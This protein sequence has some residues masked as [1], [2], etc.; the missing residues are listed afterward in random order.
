MPKS[1]E[2]TI[3]PG[4]AP[5][6]ARYDA[7]LCDIWGVLHNGVSAFKAAH[8]AASAFRRRGGR[9]ILITNAPRPFE[10][11][12]AQIARLG[13]PR[14]AYDAIISSG[15]VTRGLVR[16]L[17]GRKLFHL[18]P[19][20]DRGIYDGIEVAFADEK[21]AEAVICT[22]FFDDDTETPEHY[23]QM[24]AG[25]ARRRL[26]FVCA[27]PDIVV[28]RGASVVWCAGALAQSYERLGGSVAYAGKPH[29]PIYE[30]AIQRLEALS[31]RPVDRARV[32]AIGDG[33]KTDMLGASAFGL[34]AAF[35][36]SAVHVQAGRALDQRLIDELFAE[37]G[38]KRPVAALARLAW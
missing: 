16:D 15:D 34:D 18:G 36:P 1:S 27:N 19:D 10:S 30:M 20:R 4:I 31:G 13:V 3:L 23:A 17:A 14:D 9:V 5:L 29:A 21:G 38:F 6:T 26:P 11:V 7:W 25:F 2:T 35:I 28:E 32:L 24:L 33:L 8:E 22:G 12:A 37:A